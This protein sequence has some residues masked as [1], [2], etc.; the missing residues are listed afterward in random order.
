ALFLCKKWQ[1]VAEVRYADDFLFYRLDERTPLVS[2]FTRS[3]LYDSRMEADFAAEFAEKFGAERGKWTLSREDEVLLLGDMVMLPD[4]SLIHQDGR[5]AYLEIMGFWHP[6]YLRRKL[7]KVRAARRRNL[8]LLVYEGV[9]LTEE[10]LHDIP[11]EVL[12]FKNKPVLKEVMEV[13]E[14]V[15]E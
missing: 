1:M 2:H 13:V 3:G 5:R 10:K 6:E 11:G 15:A 4:F 7:Q 12:Y 8:I 14:R 9:N